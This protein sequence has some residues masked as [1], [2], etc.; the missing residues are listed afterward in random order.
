M[1][2]YYEAS[3]DLLKQKESNQTENK[4]Y[5]VLQIH[6]RY[7]LMPVKM[8]LLVYAAK[9]IENFL[10]ESPVQTDFSIL[11]SMADILEKML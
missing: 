2:K 10:L 5:I 3:F 4:N 11:A 9:K 1:A 6:F 8:I 7:M